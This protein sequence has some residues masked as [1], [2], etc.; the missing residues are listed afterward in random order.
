MGVMG[1]RRTTS[2]PPLLGN[3]LAASRAIAPLMKC[4]GA[5]GT[6]A[7]RRSGAVARG[8]AG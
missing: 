5:H 8:L 2:A 4:A 3:Y 6:R 7:R 1:I